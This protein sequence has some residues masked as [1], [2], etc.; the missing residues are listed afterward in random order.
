M[1]RRVAARD[2]IGESRGGPGM[3]SMENYQRVA[4]THYA[5]C[6]LYVVCLVVVAIAM[7]MGEN[8]MPALAM[9]FV[10]A[11][12]GGVAGLHFAI[13]RGAN[14]R[15]GAAKVGSVIIGVLMLPGFP[16]GTIIGAYLLWNSATEWREPRKYGP[17]LADGW[18]TGT[19]GNATDGWPTAHPSQSVSPNA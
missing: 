2:A 10:V 8:K 16:L 7:A 9:A 3:E 5:L 13:A 17:G 1:I 4:R 12:V 15:N 14:N 19:P 18:P 6:C 11:F